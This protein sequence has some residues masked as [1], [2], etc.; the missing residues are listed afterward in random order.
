M[1][2]DQETDDGSNHNK[3]EKRKENPT[4]KKSGKKHHDVNIV[5]IKEPQRE[6]LTFLKPRA[7]IC[8]FGVLPYCFVNA[9]VKN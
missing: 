4:E 6:Q 3:T 1:L 8:H 5:N 2:D 9:N 7:I